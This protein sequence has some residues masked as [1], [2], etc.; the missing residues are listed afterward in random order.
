MECLVNENV[1]NDMCNNK[2]DKAGIYLREDLV[3][4]LDVAVTFSPVVLQC[5]TVSK[6][7]LL[8]FSSCYR[9]IIFTCFSQ[10]RPVFDARA[11]C[12]QFI[13]EKDGHFTYNEY[14]RHLL[15]TIVAVER[16]YV[17]HIPFAR[18]KT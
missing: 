18:L 14:S 6:Y 17:S 9:N 15:A 8:S 1:Q 10:Q 7:S 12:V 4:F 13:V 2:Q 11:I 16:Q 5:S 3:I